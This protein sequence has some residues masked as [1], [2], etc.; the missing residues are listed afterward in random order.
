MVKAVVPLDES[1]KESKNYSLDKIKKILS[2][3]NACYVLI[4]CADP[5]QDGEMQ[6]EMSYGGDE[7]LAAY[8]IDNAQQVFDDRSQ[9][10]NSKE[11]LP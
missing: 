11:T 4:T 10:G 7:V 2:E 6:V 5:T 8:L 1:S 3:N 9:E